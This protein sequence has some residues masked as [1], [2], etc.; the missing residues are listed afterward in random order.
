MQKK[1]L[2]FGQKH[3]GSDDDRKCD[4]GE[5]LDAA[6]GGGGG[7]GPVLIPVSGIQW[8]HREASSVC[9]AP[10]SQRIPSPPL[11]NIPPLSHRSRRSPL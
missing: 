2:V 10:L 1:C 3:N 9:E 8:S 11:P 4:K 7:G 6:G 5:K